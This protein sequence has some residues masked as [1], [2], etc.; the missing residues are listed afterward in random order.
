MDMAACRA[1]FN[2][3]VDRLAG[4]LERRIYLQ[5]FLTERNT[6]RP[7]VWEDYLYIKLIVQMASKYSLLEVYT[8]SG[9]VYDFFA[10]KGAETFIN[11]HL[12][13]FFKKNLLRCKQ[14]LSSS[15]FIGKL[16]RDFF[17][18]RSMRGRRRRVLSDTM[19]VTT[20]ISDVNFASDGFNDSYFPGLKEYL[21]GRGEKVSVCP[22][23]YNV[24]NIFSVH[25]YMLQDGG[26]LMV[27]DYL[28]IT[29]Y[30]QVLQDFIRKTWLKLDSFVI[31]EVDMTSNWSWYRL[32]ERPVYSS[33]FSAFM[34]ELKRSGAENIQF[35]VNHENLI[36]EKMLLLAREEF[37]PE[38]KVIANFH[39]SMPLN[40]INLDYAG[41]ADFLVSPLPDLVLFNSPAYLQ[42]FESRWP[43]MN[44]RP[45]YAMKQ[46]YLANIDVSSGSS[47]KIAV[48]LSGRRQ[49]SL[50][51]LD[52]LNR[53]AS[54]LENYEVSFRFHPM[55]IFA[56]Q[57]YCKFVNWNVFDGNINDFM[58]QSVHVISA[59]ST[60]LLEAAIAG[61][62]VGFVYDPTKPLLNPFDNLEIGNYSLIGSYKQFESF[63]FHPEDSF[64]K[65]SCGE[66]FFLT[67]QNLDQFCALN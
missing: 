35:C 38:A 46:A 47:D 20:W 29:D 28:R 67:K 21:T 57:A 34:R 17:I 9:A 2:Q 15:I 25:R 32:Q 3:A 1:E 6:L 51:I 60:C 56:L 16:L 59:Y 53:N 8:D 10:G 66:K 55:D 63:L 50:M 42:H 7:G 5:L 41:E 11:D 43:E 4:L 61:R 49:E 36:P 31:G 22:F 33:L 30:R 37:F 62:N 12:A 13:F 58:N 14:F 19:I 39:T 44:C 45:G 24:K 27:E 40:L 52:I 48:F 54:I 18:S 26:F 65:I 23:F 64:K